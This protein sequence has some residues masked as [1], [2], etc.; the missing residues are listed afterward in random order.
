MRNIPLAVLFSAMC[1]VV[2]AGCGYIFGYVGP[3]YGTITVENTSDSNMEN[4]SLT[5][6]FGERVNR[7][8]RVEHIA[9][10]TPGESWSKTV[11]L[12]DKVISISYETNPSTSVSIEYFINGK[13]YNVENE[14][15][16]YVD[17]VN[18]DVDDSYILYTN[19]EISEYRSTKFIIKNEAY[20]VENTPPFRRPLPHNVVEVNGVEYL[21]IA[22]ALRQL[23]P[24]EYTFNVIQDIYPRAPITIPDNY[25]I[26][27]KNKTDSYFKTIQATWE[28]K[29]LFNVQGVLHLGDIASEFHESRSS[30]IIDGGGISTL[31][32]NTN[33]INIHKGAVL[34]NAHTAVLLSDEQFP[35][36]GGIMTGGVINCMTGVILAGKSPDAPV[37]NMTGGLIHGNERNIA[38]YSVRITGGTFTAP[39]GT[40]FTEGDLTQ[41]FGN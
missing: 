32:L 29:T 40:S 25:T 4:I 8:E 9:I 35:N 21:S 31:I 39:D 27:L 6:G 34:R 30:L 12:Q 14:E 19:A 26:H 37:F 23:P 36:A 33:F 5:Y 20:I 10:L 22:Q 16:V 24:G 13:K 3:W 41:T 15:D 28:N 17:F 18:V 1:F 11:K 2:L 7:S 38:N